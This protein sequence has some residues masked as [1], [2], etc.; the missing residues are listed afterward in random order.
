M[1]PPGRK[2]RRGFF[3]RPRPATRP[4]LERPPSVPTP[5]PP[6]N[7]PNCAA[8][9]LELLPGRT[10]LRCPHCTSLVF[11]EP[12]DEGVVL[13]DRDHPLD[14][15]ACRQTLVNGA[16]DGERVGHCQNCRGI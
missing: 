8:G 9:G 13:L 7:C 2:P 10:H 6:M 1:T 16:L 3:M 5:G 4:T 12:L 11:P 14:C 15:P